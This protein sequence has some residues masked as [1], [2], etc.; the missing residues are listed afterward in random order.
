MLYLTRLITAV[1]EGLPY[2]VSSIFL[3][4]DSECTI[5]TIETQDRVLQVWFANRV[6]E[7]TDHMKS[8]ERKQVEVE[9]IHHW[10]GLTN[11]ADLA[12]KGKAR[13]SDIGPRSSW[14]WGPI[15]VSFPR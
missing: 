13:I 9:K 5:T 12:T 4:T 14:Q 1:I 2:H 11:V 8:W 10:P 7:I 15:E 3:A 6:A